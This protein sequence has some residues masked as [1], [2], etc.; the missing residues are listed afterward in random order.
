V[1]ATLDLAKVSQFSVGLIVFIVD[2]AVK[3]WSLLT[4]PEVITQ[5]YGVSLGFGA[6][7]GL[8][9]TVLGWAVLILSL[10]LTWRKLGS[11]PALPTGLLFF[12]ALS[13]TV[14]RF[15]NG[16]VIDYIKIGQ[17]PSFNLADVAILLG[18][19]LLIISLT[20]LSPSQQSS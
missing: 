16:A 20:Q 6:S 5:N 10:V 13:N 2:Q 9:L 1:V 7:F 19:L 17:I 18:T 8:W 4:R 15:M 3:R 11:V 14:D 12:G